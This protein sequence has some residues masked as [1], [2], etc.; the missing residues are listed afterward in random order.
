MYIGG[1]Y[2]SDETGLVKVEDR[3]L[4][5]H[6]D[7]N[8]NVAV[9]IRGIS[10][11]RNLSEDLNVDEENIQTV[12]QQAPGKTAYWHMLYEQQR[13]IVQRIKVAMERK[14]AKLNMQFRKDATNDGA[15]TSTN[16]IEARILCDEDYQT[17]QDRY[18]DE[19]EKERILKAAINSLDELRSTLISFS[20]N[21]RTLGDVKVKHFKRGESTAKGG[22]AAIQENITKAK[23]NLLADKLRANRE[24]AKQ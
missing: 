24:A 23:E 9:T 6:F 12:L 13:S 22:H 15:K 14:Y 4:V 3:E 10:H 16:E 19:Q 20:S 18:L 21:M 2:M 8:I 7:G 17:L 5:T 11:T 1:I